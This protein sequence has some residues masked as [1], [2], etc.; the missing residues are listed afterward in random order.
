MS[1]LS[2]FPGCLSMDNEAVEC[3]QRLIELV[4]GEYMAAL[5]RGGY[6]TI[7]LHYVH[8]EVPSQLTSER[9]A[10]ATELHDVD[11]QTSWQPL[12]PSCPVWHAV[13]WQDLSQR[14][15]MAGF[16]QV[17]A[18][19]EDYINERLNSLWQQSHNAED[20]GFPVDWSHSEL[21]SA[22]FGAPV[23]QLVHERKAIL[24]IPLKSGTVMPIR[25]QTVV[26]RNVDRFHFADWVVAFTVDLKLCDHAAVPGVDAKWR[27]NFAS[28]HSTW[29]DVSFSHL[30]MDL[31]HA[32][33]NLDCSNFADLSTTNDKGSIEKAHAAV[34]YVRDHYLKELA[35]AGYHILASIPVSRAPPKH[36]GVLTS[37]TFF[38]DA[39][40]VT[41]VPFDE[42][43]LSE[44][45]V[46]I[47][48]MHLGRPL[49]SP[50]PHHLGTWITDVLTPS[51]GTLA[52]SASSFLH[53]YLLP[54]L[55]EVNART[56]VER[57]SQGASGVNL[58]RWCYHP[59]R[60]TGDCRF[61]PAVSPISSE[62]PLRF[63]WS[64]V[65]KFYL[66]QDGSCFVRSETENYIDFPTAPSLDGLDIVLRGSVN[67]EQTDKCWK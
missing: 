28:S 21:F 11:S 40:D 7:D 23:F 17:N 59:R 33:L 26:S 13:T 8:Q 14:I 52:L 60:V 2:R 1:Q 27:S 16:D 58:V 22:T 5:E 38:V 3:K 49:P 31:Q 20:E 67:L 43:S 39:K 66:E 45:S 18:L 54:S 42:N 25:S 61:K 30:Y 35:S 63:R 6:L 41:D 36:P 19:T 64:I 10:A 55:S 34:I 32:E 12:L 44:S 15:D 51:Q 4:H 9:G 53:A 65:R 62:G 29:N 47:A 37:V 48:G 57:V 56:R 46:Q 50:L 24:W